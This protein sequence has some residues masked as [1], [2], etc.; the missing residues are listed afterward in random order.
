[1]KSKATG[2]VLMTEGSIPKAIVR[3]ALPIFWGNLFQQLYNIV[4]ALIVGN[5]VGKNALAAVTSSGTL[6]FLM[7]GLFSGVFIGAGVVIARY[8]GAQEHEKVSDA[9][10]TTAAFGLSAGAF[11]TVVGVLLTPTLLRLINTPADV[12]PNSI[13]YFRIYF[14]GAMSLVLYNTAS[15]IFQAL[16]DSK[17]PLYYLI[18][19]SM[20]NVLLD[21][22]F[23]AV[24]HWGI[25]GAAFATILAQTVSVC[26]AWWRLTHMEGPYRVQIKKIRFHK[27]M[28]GQVLNMGIPS[29]IQNS[30]ISIA[31]IIVQANINSY[32]ADAMAGCGAY[33]KIQ[34]FAFLPIT[35]F[36]LALTTFVGQN[37]GAKQ[38]DRA[39]RGARFG[40]FSSV[41]L[42]ELM[43]VLIYLFAP[44][45]I[46]AFNGSEE[47]VAFGALQAHTDSLFYFLLAFSH[48]A[49]GV[50]R[51]AGRSIIPMLVM[52]VCW[53]AIRITY[54]SIITTIVPDI[55]A[56]FWA[57]PMTWC[58]SS[59]AFVFF[60]LK[61]DWSH[62]YEKQQARALEKQLV[63]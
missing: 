12:L 33:A 38:V 51:G 37:L 49:S 27:G 29:G 13:L 17:H 63:E 18:L 7:V 60:L 57:Y 8:F 53:C 19:S 6:I 55:V 41:I 15:G 45:L 34:G 28:L 2:A 59:I 5:F 3:F 35:S 44:Y 48:A 32:G 40:I 23:V 10:H 26:L 62:Y 30:V 11:L 24:F 46:A 14:G 61:G 25:A 4:D 36:A 52:M 50:L 21:L 16:G 20:L 22:L 42:A 54:I 9:I 56:I 47:V 39:K 1:M 43:G 31:N 58:L